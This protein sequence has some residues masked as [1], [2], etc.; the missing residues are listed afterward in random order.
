MIVYADTSFVIKLVIDE[1]GTDLATHV[2]SSATSVVSVPL[3]YVEARAA[4]AGAHRGGRIDAAGLRRAK[5]GLS[6]LCADILTVEVSSDLLDSAG[7]LADRY[8]LRG[9]DAVHLAG[10]MLVAAEVLA[11]ADVALCT[12]AMRSGIAVANVGRAV[13]GEV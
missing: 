12:A 4:L 9:Y 7:D 3:M 2:W 8:A 6:A 13:G 11:S 1:V 10:A 5:G